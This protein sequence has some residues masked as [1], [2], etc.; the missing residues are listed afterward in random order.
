MVSN[1]STWETVATLTAHSAL[2]PA[3]DSLARGYD[4]VLNQIKDF[5]DSS[6]YEK[7][8]QLIARLPPQFSGVKFNQYL[9]PHPERSLPLHSR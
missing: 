1:I 6:D 3:K 5:V 9:P 7:A 8:D 2:W 4:D